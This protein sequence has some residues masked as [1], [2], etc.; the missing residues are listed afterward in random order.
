[1]VVKQDQADLSKLLNLDIGY[2]GGFLSLRMNELVMEAAQR[3]GFKDI[4]ERHGFVLQHFIDSDRGITELARRME[5]TQQGASKVV[6]EMVAI[7]L[8]EDCPS[9]DRR[10]RRVRLS[11]QGWK[12]V[13]FTRRTR[14][15]L[16]RKLLGKVGQ[17]G[18]DITR[19]TLIQCLEKLGK[20]D[21]IL[22]RRVRAPR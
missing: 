12:F 18:Y 4:R 1:M 19:E 11:E 13:K 21:R 8:L 17:Q 9:H 3:A 15:K 2:L 5:V 16:E 10:T 22:S 20:L 6:A 7:G 14:S